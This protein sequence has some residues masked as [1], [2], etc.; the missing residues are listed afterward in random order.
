MD[1]KQKADATAGNAEAELKYR[2]LFDQSP[3]GIL[4]LDQEGHILDFNTSAHLQL[5]YTRDEFSKLHIA[6]IDPV[7]RPDEI[8]TKIGEMLRLGKAEHD[9]KH[10]TKQGEI[11]DVHVIVQRIVLSGRT[12]LHAIWRDI[13]QYK[14]AEETIKAAS[15]AAWEEKS[16]TE[17]I[18]AAM[19]DAVNIQNTQYKILYQNAV[20]I[21]IY[22]NHVGEYCYQAFQHKDQ[23]C[24]H[25]HLTMAFAD[26][27]IHRMEQNRTTDAGMRYYDITASPVRDSTGTIIA[28]IEIVRDIT[29]R[30]RVEERTLFITKALE[31]ASDAIGISDAQGRHF[32]QNKA[33]S[34]LF[35]YTTAEELEKAGGGAAV[36]NNPGV[37]REMFDNIMHG[38]SWVGE[39]EMV[40][41][42]G[43]VFPAFERADAIQDSQG[44]LIGLIGIITDI[45]E[46]KKS[47]EALLYFRMAVSSATDAIGMSTPEG[48][49]YYQNEAFTQLF[50]LTVDQ[51]DGISGP[52]T[53]VYVD[54]KIGR[55]VF[56]TL[57]QG[58]VFV[59]EAKMFNKDRKERDIYIRAYPVKNK[60]GRIV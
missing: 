50:G 33:L 36:V 52:P 27:R 35:G 60:Q 53:T 54:E 3:D 32:Y 15:A 30:K 8:K 58:E 14:Q 10:R 12:V 2:T 16:K 49:H 43:R 26:G 56:D 38:K 5:G 40:T 6:D 25:C 24:G 29:E 44:N 9:V 4:I 57:M 28:G 18:L 34:D 31:S 20:S 37:A 45:T 21:G 1:N 59:G 17:A 13:T 39:L 23:A 47:E 55:T 42:T 51:V 41:K 19:G 46:R 7:E 11:R 22:G 48:K